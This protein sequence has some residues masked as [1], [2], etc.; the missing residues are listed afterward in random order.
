MKLRLP[1]LTRPALRLW[2]AWLGMN[3][4]F[5]HLRCTKAPFIRG[6]RRVRG[7]GRAMAL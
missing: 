3:G 6:Q 2:G 7:Y 4:T 1:T 5:I